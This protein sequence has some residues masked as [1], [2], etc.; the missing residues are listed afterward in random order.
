MKQSAIEQSKREVARNMIANAICESTYTY[1]TIDQSIV[2]NDDGTYEAIP[3]VYL[4]DASYLGSR[5][6]VSSGIDIES[7]D[8]N[9]TL[10]I[11][12]DNF[13]WDDWAAANSAVLDDLIDW[14][15]T[16]WDWQPESEQYNC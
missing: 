12:Q 13:N 8:P 6:L 15:V 16:E 5:N 3:S 2:I 14:A 9:D 10:N 11:P 1:T 4:S 7:I